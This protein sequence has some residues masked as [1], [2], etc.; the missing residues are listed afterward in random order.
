MKKRAA[1]HK[2]SES[3]KTIIRLCNDEFEMRLKE[4]TGDVCDE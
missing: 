1:S 3:M 2:F 4:M